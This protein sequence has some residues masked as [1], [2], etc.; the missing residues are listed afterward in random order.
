[1]I[2]SRCLHIGEEEEQQIR[3]VFHA[4]KG[5]LEKQLNSIQEPKTLR[6]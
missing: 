4:E 2:K 6:K 3:Y 5:F 1:M